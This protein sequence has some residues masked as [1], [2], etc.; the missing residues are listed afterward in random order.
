MSS[1]TENCDDSGFFRSTIIPKRKAKGLQNTLQNEYDLALDI[2]QS[3]LLNKN[4]HKSN[5]KVN[6]RQLFFEFNQP[7]RSK[8]KKFKS[9]IL[10][11][12]TQEDRQR[13]ITEKAAVVLLDDGTVRS[14]TGQNEAKNNEALVSDVLSKYHNRVS[15]LWKLS[16]NVGDSGWL[17][18]DVKS[19]FIIDSLTSEI[20]INVERDISPQS[21]QKLNEEGSKLKITHSIETSLLKLNLPKATLDQDWRRLINN[22]SFCDIRAISKDQRTFHLH[23]LIMNVRCP[24]SLDK[25]IQF[26]LIKYN[27]STILVFL[28]YLY[29]GTLNDLKITELQDLMGLASDFEHCELITV[30]NCLQIN[31]NKGTA[32]S[33]VVTSNLPPDLRS[34]FAEQ[35]KNLNKKQSDSLCW[36]DRD[37]FECEVVDLTQGSYSSSNCDENESNVDKSYWSFVQHQKKKDEEMREEEIE[38]SLMISEREKLVSCFERQDEMMHEILR[39]YDEDKINVINPHKEFEK[40]EKLET[41]GSNMKGLGEKFTLRNKTTDTCIII[42]SDSD[43]RGSKSEDDNMVQKKSSPNNIEYD[44]PY[45]DPYE[46]YNHFSACNFSPVKVHTQSRL[47]EESNHDDF[48]LNT[49]MKVGEE[50]LSPE[51]DST[52]I[53]TKTT[54]ISST[55]KSLQFRSK[56]TGAGLAAN[57]IIRKSL[58]LAIKS[59]KQTTIKKVNTKEERRRRKS[60]VLDNFSTSLMNE[61]SKSPRFRSSTPLS[62]RDYIELTPSVKDIDVNEPITPYP[63]YSRMGDSL[64]K[65]H[66]AKYGLKRNL[67]KRKAQKILKH[68]YEELHPFLNEE[69]GRLVKAVINTPKNV[70]KTKKNI[71][72]KRI[73]KETKNCNQD[74]EKQTGK[75]INED[76]KVNA[77]R[78][79]NSS[80]HEGTMIYDFSGSD[81]DTVIDT[82][83]RNL[84]DLSSAMN[85]FLKLNPDFHKKILLYEPIWVKDLQKQLKETFKKHYKM[86]DLMNYLDQQ[87]GTKSVN[88]QL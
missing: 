20:T 73:Q 11:N 72:R 78:E 13:I 62:K 35:K 23:S 39:V 15:R 22:E 1:P 40:D 85:D 10:I 6:K 70:K 87:E 88:S 67:G 17:V 43:T 8:N 21:P 63:E 30:L 25:D 76:K 55:R 37:L 86:E 29:C 26:I 79:E 31:L 48:H 50:N 27:L 28:E 2:A 82:T 32:S 71:S 19:Y 34:E 47:A 75:K 58:G 77:S 7:K 45:F 65:E 36:Q 41:G 57:R 5:S 44:L 64:L 81:D 74:I 49:T 38:K 12:R 4:E 16:D 59:P 84:Q 52:P 3:K 66:L 61:F 83:P 46:D 14:R 56:K 51:M 60:A 18:E 69:T 9:S 68:I 33:E 24:G 42:S 80:S 53:R 54:R